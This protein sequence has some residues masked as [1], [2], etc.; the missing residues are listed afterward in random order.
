MQ[1]TKVIVLVL[2]LHQLLYLSEIIVLKGSRRF[3]PEKKNVMETKWLQYLNVKVK[4]QMNYHADDFKWRA[5]Y[6]DIEF[7]FMLYG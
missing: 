3:N 2:L 5:R 7:K 4:S 1:V 6:N